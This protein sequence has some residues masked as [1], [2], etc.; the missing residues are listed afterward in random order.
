MITDSVLER[1]F[2]VTTEGGHGSAVVVEAETSRPLRATVAEDRGG[3][4]PGEGY[5]IYRARDVEGTVEGEYGAVLERAAQW[6]GVSAKYMGGV[7][8]TYERRAVR[9]WERERRSREAKLA[10]VSS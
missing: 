8:E 9:W 2:P 5:R 4:R 3:L 7:V 1:Y 10:D 6:A